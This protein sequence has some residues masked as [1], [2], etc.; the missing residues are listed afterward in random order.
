MPDVLAFRWRHPRGRNLV[1]TLRDTDKHKRS[2]SEI[3]VE[4]VLTSIKLPC[5]LENFRR[6]ELAEVGRG[7]A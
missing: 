6:P 7:S 5:L 4:F 1:I 3:E 2:F